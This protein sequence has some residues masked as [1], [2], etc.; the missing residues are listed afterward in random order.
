MV[1]LGR[2]KE[3]LVPFPHADSPLRK[4]PD[5]QVAA[6][7]FSNEISSELPPGEPHS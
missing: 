7:Q 6:T 4:R 5:L 2:C 3:T 1:G